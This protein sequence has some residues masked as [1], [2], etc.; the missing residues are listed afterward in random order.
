MFI[1]LLSKNKRTLSKVS[2]SEIDKN[3]GLLK[4]LTRIRIRLKAPI[5]VFTKTTKPVALRARN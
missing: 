5:E 2:V 3:E 4:N 1:T